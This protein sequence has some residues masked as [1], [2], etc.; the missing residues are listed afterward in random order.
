MTGRPRH[1][2]GL[3]FGRYFLNGT[4][5]VSVAL[6]LTFLLHESQWVQSFERTNL[7]S[8][9][10]LV[11]LGEPSDRV[12]VV[13][14][15]D[16]DYKVLF[17]RQSPLKSGVIKQLIVSIRQAGAA[18]VGVD[19]LTE[20]WPREAIAEIERE[21]QIPIVWLR[22]VVVE[23]GSVQKERER[24]DKKNPWTCKGPSVLHKPSGVVREY[25]ARVGFAGGGSA[26]SF[27]RLIE[28]VYHDHSTRACQDPP[29]GLPER[30]LVPFLRGPRQ[31]HRFMASDVFAGFG[32]SDW[33]RNRL[34]D[35]Q[36]VLLGGAFE[37]SRDYHATPFEDRAYGVNIQASI[38]AADLAHQQIASTAWWIFLAFDAALGLALVAAGWYFGFLS[39]LAITAGAVLL[40][41]GGS[42]LLYQYFQIYLSFVPVLVGVSMHF[43]VEHLR[44]HWKLRL[45]IV[46]SDGQHGSPARPSGGVRRRRRRA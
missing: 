19:V 25:D 35:G 41:F 34:M 5:W 4:I 3:T 8:I 7:D 28:T 42:L 29:P 30:Q 24:E 13:M 31:P 9:A 38:I 11:K 15:T 10:T 23:N 6:L 26:L 12:A 2:T 16:D 18:V 27:T 33:Q 40:V 22:D 45:Q 1:K 20:E 21:A 44:E 46:P 36:I 37:A 39:F 14:I 32:N 43:L 17:D